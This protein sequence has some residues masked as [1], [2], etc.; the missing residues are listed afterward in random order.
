MQFR[1]IISH[2]PNKGQKTLQSNRT[3]EIRYQLGATECRIDTITQTQ[4]SPE[5]RGDASMLDMKPVDFGT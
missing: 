5:A 1:L 4:C 3:Y 2:S